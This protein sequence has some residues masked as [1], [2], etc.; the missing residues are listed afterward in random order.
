MIFQPSAAQIKRILAKHQGRVHICADEHPGNTFKRGPTNNKNCLAYRIT[1]LLRRKG[2]MCATDV[3][4]ELG[5]ER[6]FASSALSNLRAKGRLVYRLEPNKDKA[7]RMFFRI[8][9]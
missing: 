1:E 2:E 8:A 9:K 4:K 6:R 3:A 5:V 7:R